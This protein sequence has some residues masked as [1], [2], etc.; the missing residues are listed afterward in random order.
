MNPSKNIRKPSGC[1]ARDRRLHPRKSEKLHALLSASGNPWAALAF[2]LGIETRL[3]KGALFNVRWQQ[4]DL[5]NRLL[6]FPPDARGAKNTAVP[7]V[8]RLSCRAVTV[9]RRLAADS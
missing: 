3:R 2:E 5:E 8:L 7:A 4:L 9:F 1:E 6:R